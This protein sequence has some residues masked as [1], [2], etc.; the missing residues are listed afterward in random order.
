MKYRLSLKPPGYSIQRF[1]RGCTAA[2]W[3]LVVLWLPISRLAASSD[4]LSRALA[5]P[6]ASLIAEEQGRPVIV[7]QADRPMVPA[8]TMKIITA[9]A[10][11]QR[12]GLHHHFH[13]DFYR[14]ADGWLWAKGYGDPYLV[15]MELDAIAAALKEQGVRS[16]AGI[17]TDDNYFSPEVEIAGRSF[18]NNPYDAPVTALA[19]NF[20][21][22]DVRRSGGSWRS[23][24]AETPLTPLAMTLAERLGAGESRV[25]LRERELGV[26]YFGELLAAKLTTAGIEVGSSLRQ[27]RVPADA[28][29][30]YR[31]ANSRDLRSVLTAMLKYSNNFIANDLFLLLA[32]HGDGRPVSMP[33]AQHSAANWV[34]KTFGWQDYRIEDGAGLS[35]GNRL[36]AR[37]LLAA[38]KAFAAYRDLL[39]EHGGHV[40]A[41]TGTLTGVSC[42]AG[43]VHRHGHWEP[44]SLMINQAVAHDFRFHVADAL[45]DIPELER[46][47]QDGSC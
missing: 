44:F 9:L 20:N 25:N 13:T 24:E 41:K 15:S 45:A 21:T 17:G 34:D 12:W 5:L 29:R 2:L 42:Y 14:S 33:E 36:S 31:H 23:A 37:Q 16:V 39:P 1:R 3:A 4:A 38:V 46:L 11:I 22:V 26:R 43:F 19:A 10:A 27:G 40:F 30:I 35:H 6:K 32:D 47:C 8:S 28:K 18:S 7:H